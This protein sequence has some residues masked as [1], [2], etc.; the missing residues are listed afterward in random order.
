MLVVID[1]EASISAVVDDADKGYTGRP[2]ER[3]RLC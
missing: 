1:C 2:K 3:G